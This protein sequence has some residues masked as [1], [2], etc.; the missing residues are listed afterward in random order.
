MRLLFVTATRIGDAL[1]TT[2]LLAHLIDRHPG[3]QVT[4]ACGPAA[5]GLFATVPGLEELILLPKGRFARHC[6]HLWRRTVGRR[7]DMVVDLRGSSL[8]WCLLA[9]ERR[10]IAVGDICEVL[11]EDKDDPGEQGYG[12]TPLGVRIVMPVWDAAHKQTMEY[13]KQ[14]NLSDL[15]EQA[16]AKHVRK[17]SEER[18]DFAI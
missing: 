1:L 4:V 10:R 5:A 11:R 9:K 18:M 17:D 14:V 7:W 16:T 3:A 6:L 12:G 15:C 13:L 8:A 2:G